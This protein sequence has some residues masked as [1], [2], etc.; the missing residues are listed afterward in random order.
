MLDMK[1]AQKWFKI[2][3]EVKKY[4]RKIFKRTRYNSLIW[5]SFINTDYNY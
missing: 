3:K 2:I 5:D 4:V 1:M